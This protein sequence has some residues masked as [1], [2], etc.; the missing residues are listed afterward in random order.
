MNGVWP[1]VVSIAAGAGV[2]LLFAP[3][4]RQALQ[5]TV[6]IKSYIDLHRLHAEWR[7]RTAENL[8]PV[9]AEAASSR[10]ALHQTSRAVGDE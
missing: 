2:A 8:G 4:P 6:R 5:A 9:W 1:I 3:A 10:P 7:S